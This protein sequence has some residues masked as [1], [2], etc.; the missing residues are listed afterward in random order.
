[1][2]ESCVVLDGDKTCGLAGHVGRAFE[3]CVVL[4]GDKTTL[5]LR[6]ARERLR[7]VLF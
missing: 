5:Y 4:D 7:V 6:H 3:S 1:M 2:F